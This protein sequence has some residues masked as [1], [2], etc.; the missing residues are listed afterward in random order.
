M[1][2]SDLSIRELAALICEKL[3]KEGL[4]ATLSGGAW[5]EIEDQPDKFNEFIK[6]IET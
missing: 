4:R 2:L 6:K 5:A 1:D 3:T